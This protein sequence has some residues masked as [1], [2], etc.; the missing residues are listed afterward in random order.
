M[1]NLSELACHFRSLHTAD[2]PLVLPNAWDIA[3][4]RIIAQA[5]AAAIATTSAGVAWDLGAA[6]G[7]QVDRGAALDRLARITAAVDVP[8]T[9]DIEDGYAQS[10]DG[11]AETIRA[12]LA[13]GAV[14]VNVEDGARPALEH[15]QRIAVARAAADA[16]GVP[17]FINARIDVYLAGI[18]PAADRL[19]ETL[20]RAADCL[21]AGADGIFVPGVV[22]GATVEALA[23]GIDAPLNVMAGPGA[24]GTA[25][26]AKLGAA[27]ISVGAGIAQ[28][29]HALVRDA[30]RELLGAGTYTALSGGYGYQELNT[31][32]GTDQGLSAEVC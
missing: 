1:T 24:P 20:K 11:V 15:A 16:E 26:L 27:R 22:E 32:M 19:D 3:S 8:V 31:L 4:A 25:E 7:G 6:D 2:R 28:A 30:A 13:A 9:A 29:V 12:V 14:G 10:A 21:A 23:R 5:G 17:L 18:G